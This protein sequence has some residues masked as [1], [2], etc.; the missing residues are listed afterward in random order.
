VTAAAAKGHSTTKGAQ[1]TEWAAR[2]HRPRGRP[3]KNPVRVAP[4]LTTSPSTAGASS[5]SLSTH[6][7]APTSGTLETEVMALRTTLGALP[8]SE[9][10]RLTSIWGSLTLRRRRW[11]LAFL[12]TGNGSEAARIA[13]YKVS[14]PNSAATYMEGLE[15]AGVVRLIKGEG[16]APNRIKLAPNF[17][18]LRRAPL[19][20]SKRVGG[21]RDPRE[22]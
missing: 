5:H 4:G 14:A 9:A 11:L 19:L 8:P 3:T 15:R 20:K 18:E 13:G 21:E 16:T 10:A 17:R 6:A 7:A 1:P 12:Q 22:P 2:S